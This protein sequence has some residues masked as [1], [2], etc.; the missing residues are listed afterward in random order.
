M[1]TQTTV[2]IKYNV[3]YGNMP[4][5]REHKLLCYSKHAPT[6]RQSSLQHVRRQRGTC[7]ANSVYQKGKTKVVTNWVFA[8]PTPLIRSLTYLI[9]RVDPQTCFLNLSFKKISQQI[10]ELRDQHSPL[11]TD[12]AYHWYNSLLLPD[13]DNCDKPW[14]PA[15]IRGH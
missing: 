10:L 15:T 14:Y 2:I 8:L 5:K 11:P 6:D 3:H 13:R 9:H 7:I 12:L 4:T 1:V